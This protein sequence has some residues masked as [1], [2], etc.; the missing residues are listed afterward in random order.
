MLN[1][2]PPS[3]SRFLGEAG[4]PMSPR[5]S[6]S[7]CAGNT[8][9]GST[10]A[11]ATQRCAKD[12]HSPC[13]SPPDVPKTSFIPSAPPTQGPT[14]EH[15]VVMFKP[16]RLLKLSSQGDLGGVQV[17][18]QDGPGCDS[19]VARSDHLSDTIRPARSLHQRV[20]LCH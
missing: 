13:T 12:W 9:L 4:R 20:L 3:A 10:S 14:W 2:L 18:L 1:S 16:R 15:V 17:I 19:P 5:P 8:G 6:L 7:P 11:Q